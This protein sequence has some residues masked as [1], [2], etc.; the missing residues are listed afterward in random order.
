MPCS[1]ALSCLERSR[2][3]LPELLC[4]LL[5]KPLDVLA[6][7]DALCLPV[8]CRPYLSRM[9]LDAFHLELACLPGT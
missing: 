1:T 8:V 4:E 3:T 7:I 9:N 6:Q 5:R 2:N